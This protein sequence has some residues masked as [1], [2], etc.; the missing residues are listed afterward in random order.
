[1]DDGS[2]ILVAV[3]S[4][5]KTRNLNKSPSSKSC[6]LYDPGTDTWSTAPDLVTPRSGHSATLLPGGKVLLVGGRDENGGPTHRVE[7]YEPQ[8]ISGDFRLKL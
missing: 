5:L 7:V 1:M 4:V 8:V 2:K 3:G 6:L